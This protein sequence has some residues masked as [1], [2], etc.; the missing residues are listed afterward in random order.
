MIT[1]NSW[2]FPI[3]KDSSHSFLHFTPSPIQ[4]NGFQFR[5]RKKLLQSEIP[6]VEFGIARREIP[7]FTPLI[8][9]FAAASLQNF[10][11]SPLLCTSPIVHFLYL[12]FL[13]LISE[14]PFKKL[15][16]SQLCI[17]DTQPKSVFEITINYEQRP[18]TSLT[19]FFDKILLN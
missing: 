2:I 15:R 19:I 17:D 6:T 14:L 11:E 9:K 13:V 5:I 8:A 16:F 10:V 1:E 18:R 3:R 4:G 7:F 12:C